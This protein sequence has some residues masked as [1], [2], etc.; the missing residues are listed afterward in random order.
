M[1]ATHYTDSRGNPVEIAT[2]PYPHLKA[3]YE[4]AVR[5]EERKHSFAHEQGEDYDNPEREA[6]IDAMKARLDALDAA[7]ADAVEAGEGFR[8]R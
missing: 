4:K 7:H 5:T 2:M 1:T 8:P 6:E 3:A